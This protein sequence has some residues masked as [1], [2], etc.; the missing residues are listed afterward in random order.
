MGAAATQA[1]FNI[2]NRNVVF[3]AIKEGLTAEEVI[4]RVTDPEY[5]SETE[6][7]QYG[8][9]TMHDGF[10]RTAG[11]TTPLR[12]GMV[13]NEEGSTRYAGVMADPGQLG[14]ARFLDHAA[15]P[16]LQCPAL[17]HARVRR[18]TAHAGSGRDGRA[19][20]LVHDG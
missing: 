4:A 16:G 15:G 13:T 3:E 17:R 5:D 11:F 6:R 19:T 20:A 8:V 7:R 9:V 2:D 18:Q 14:D 10:V 1:G 12:Q